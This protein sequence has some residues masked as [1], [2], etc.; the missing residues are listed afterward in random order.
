MATSRRFR[1]VEFFHGA[2]SLALRPTFTLKEM[3]GFLS[4]YLP[5]GPKVR[6]VIAPVIRF[7]PF[8]AQRYP[9]RATWRRT[10]G[11]VSMNLHSR[12]AFLGIL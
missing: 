5:L 11:L 1:N 3:G 12:V 9:W 10:A 2:G 7:R 6:L 4:G 8:C